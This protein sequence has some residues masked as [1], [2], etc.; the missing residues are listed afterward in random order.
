MTD[1]AIDESLIPKINEQTKGENKD[2]DEQEAYF[3]LCQIF[4]Y[5]Q[6]TQDYAKFQLDLSEWKRRFPLD[7]FSDDYKL[8]IKRMLSKEF[9]ESV[10]KGFLA[11]EELSQKDPAKGLEKLRKVLNRAEKHK[12]KNTLNKDL[13]S[14]YVEYPLKFLKQHYPHIVSVLLSKSNLDKILEK[15]NSSDAFRDL[16]HIT[17]NSAQYAN[18]AEFTAAIEEWKKCFPTNDFNDEYRPNVAHELATYSDRRKLEELFPEIIFSDLPQSDTIP[19]AIT[20]NVKS[21]APVTKEALYDFFKITNQNIEDMDSLFNWLCKYSKYINTFEP[22]AKETIVSTLMTKY[23]KEL[24]TGKTDFRIPTMESLPDEYI[25]QEEY[26]NIEQTKKDAFLSFLGILSTDHELTHDDRYKLNVI[27]SNAKKVDA[28][29]EAKIEEKVEVLGK[30][31]KDD[32]LTPSDE[33]YLEPVIQTYDAK[34]ITEISP[35]KVI[36]EPI[37]EKPKNDETKSALE[38]LDESKD[39]SDD[40]SVGFIYTKNSESSTSSSNN[41]GGFASGLRLSS[42]DNKISSNDEEN[43]KKNNR[44]KLSDSSSSSSSDGGGG[45]SAGIQLP[46][47]EQIEKD[48]SSLDDDLLE[49]L[50]K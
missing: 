44:T 41:G 15:F 40:E 9:L 28:I 36:L 26:T 45:F 12:D 27:N 10:L 25:S 18:A 33:V 38:D 39:I 11:F 17:E 4:A 2:F 29:K 49:E 19:T 43:S 47:E 6:A 30:M 23:A 7:L 14:L 5:A 37:Q 42:F 35:K 31:G 3:L 34:E 1:S 46:A 20:Q 50:E 22:V 16:A 48:E 13:D 32:F 8:K 24:P 21:F